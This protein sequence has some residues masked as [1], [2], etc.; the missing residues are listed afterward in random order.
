[1]PHDLATLKPTAAT[2]CLPLAAFHPATKLVAC[3]VFAFCISLLSHH[4][5]ALM[6]CTIPLCLA[7]AGRLSLTTLAKKH[8]P[9]NF[10]F[11]F[12]WLFLPLHFSSGSFSFSR[13][14][15]ELAALITL[16]GNAIAT[17]MLVLLGTSTIGEIC[18]GLLKLH[19]PEKLVTLLLLTHANIAYMMASYATISSAAKLRGFVST[20]SLASYKTSAYLAAMLLVRSWQ[21]AQRVTKAMRLRGFS[22]QYPLLQLPPAVSYHHATLF[23]VNISLISATL[24]IANIFISY[25]I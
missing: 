12:L 6:A 1:M 13:S 15:V 19:L 2:T 25:S 9:V 18:R 16:K 11:I 17:M 5:L 23:L 8:W 24:L 3:F 21:R 14:G 22:G 10:F 7:V 4:T 20:R